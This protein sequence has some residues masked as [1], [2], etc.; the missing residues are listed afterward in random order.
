MRDPSLNV[1]VGNGP[2]LGAAKKKGL[3]SI[4][5]GSVCWET[6]LN[7]KVKTSLLTQPGSTV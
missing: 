6:F 2:L 4:V 5:Q 3:E 7:E 1:L